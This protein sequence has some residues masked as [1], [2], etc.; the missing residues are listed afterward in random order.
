ME[1][2]IIYIYIYIQNTSTKGT[3]DI[4]EGMDTNDTLQQQTRRISKKGM[5]HLVILFSQFLYGIE[6]SSFL[7]LGPTVQESSNNILAYHVSTKC[8]LQK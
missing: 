5:V 1:G 2:D 8:P 3:R 6:A 7:R 4:L